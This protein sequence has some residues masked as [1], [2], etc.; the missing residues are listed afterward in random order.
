MTVS[1]EH[2]RFVWNT[3]SFISDRSPRKAMFGSNI[4]HVAETVQLQ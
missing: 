3:D 1:G 4:E 2:R